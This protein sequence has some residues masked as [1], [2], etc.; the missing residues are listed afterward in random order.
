MSF[1]F[2]H[3]SPRACQRGPGT[4]KQLIWEVREGGRK[5]TKGRQRDQESDEL[6]EVILSTVLKGQ[7]KFTELP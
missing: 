3:V 7:V 5:S 6:I 2:D 4:N 1:L